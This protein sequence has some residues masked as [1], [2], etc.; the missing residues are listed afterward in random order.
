MKTAS[1]VI[2]RL[3]WDQDVEKEEFIVGY[4]DRIVGLQ[5]RRFTDFTWEDLA[6]V[7][8]FAL[9]IP[10]HR[11]QYFKYKTVKVWDKN[12]RLDDVFGSTG[13]GITITEAVAKYETTIGVQEGAAKNDANVDSESDEA[14]DEEGYCHDEIC[15]EFIRNKAEDKENDKLNE[16]CGVNSD[17]YSINA[18]GNAEEGLV[19]KSG[20]ATGNT[21]HKREKESNFFL[22][23]KLQDEDTVENLVD[24]QRQVIELYPFYKDHAMSKNSFHLTLRL[25]SLR[26]DDE[27]RTC[28]SVMKKI[29][30]KVREKM[31]KI[32]ALS[33]KGLDHFGPNVIYVRVKYTAA[34]MEL[35][36]Y[37][38]RKFEDAGVN[39]VSHQLVPHV[40]LFKVPRA[41]RERGKT[42]P[43]MLLRFN[44]L[45][46]GAQPVDNIHVCQM[47][48]L[49]E[50]SD[51]YTIASSIELQE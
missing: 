36:D 51:F 9:A 42:Q 23:L 22:G 24:V 7:D 4:M 12:E 8:Q 2:K 45:E 25:L 28:A 17:G 48:T 11:I 5:E 43:P 40:T 37:I 31:Q 44:N 35:L 26:S 13:S 50:T 19:N 27:I 33:F 21:S 18:N 20:A 29:S 46:L 34:F 16:A 10:Q 41:K 6:S 15:E 49:T 47:G 32:E 38:T 30:D 1:D 39:V 14:D 3:Q